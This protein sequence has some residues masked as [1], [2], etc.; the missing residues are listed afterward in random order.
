[1]P[2]QTILT[3]N[4]AAMPDVQR[5]LEDL[6]RT[7]P[8]GV[9]LV[10]VSKFKTAEEI[11]KAY[12]CGQRMFGE[13]RALEMRDKHEALP[14]DIEWHFIGHLQTNKVKYII[15]FVAMIQ[16]IDSEKLLQEVDKQAKQHGRI[17]DCLLQIHISRDEAKFGFS[18]DECK[19]VLA[20]ITAGRYANVQITGLM[21]MATYT[22]DLQ[23]VTQEFRNLKCF[24]DE[25]KLAMPP[26]FR[27]LSMGMSG[28]YETAI[29]EGA[30]MVRVG[31]KIFGER[32]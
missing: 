13:S 29:S 6:L 19:E 8:E 12:S 1:M 31:S 26:V 18:F 23:I 11:M 21:G 22:D 28:D 2:A 5:N 16:S 20:S 14:K 10:A 9:A 15:P 3:T 27:L 17:V 4:L 25:L 32:N 24:F 30:S 7:L